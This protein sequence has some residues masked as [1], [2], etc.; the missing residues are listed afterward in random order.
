MFV[1]ASGN[2][3]LLYQYEDPDSLNYIRSRKYQGK[4]KQQRIREDAVTILDTKLMTKEQK[5][6]YF[7][8]LGY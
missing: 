8:S 1:T 5:Q 2:H 3:S 4:G 7:K 6:E